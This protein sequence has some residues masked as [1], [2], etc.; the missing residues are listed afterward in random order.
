M[1]EEML[2]A[3]GLGDGFDEG[4]IDQRRHEVVDLIAD[5]GQLR[6]DSRQSTWSESIKSSNRATS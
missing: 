1:N 6:P 4:S 3:Y 5:W 2:H